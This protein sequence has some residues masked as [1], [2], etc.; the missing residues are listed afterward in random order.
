MTDG[1]LLV[2]TVVLWLIVYCSIHVLASW[3]NSSK[4]EK[5]G[6]VLMLSVALLILSSFELGKRTE[7]KNGTLQSKSQQKQ[8]PTNAN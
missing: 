7:I 1:L 3:T 8:E 6:T 2:A 4:G 5:V